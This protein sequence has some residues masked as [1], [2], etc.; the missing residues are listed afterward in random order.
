[1]M[2]APETEVNKWKHVE[3][4]KGDACCATGDLSPEQKI[5]SLVPKLNEVLYEIL[6][7]EPYHRATMLV[8]QKGSIA[9]KQQA[10]IESIQSFT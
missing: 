1:M 6:C 8:T 4:K 7:E 2:Q 9:I 10:I 5:V 3:D